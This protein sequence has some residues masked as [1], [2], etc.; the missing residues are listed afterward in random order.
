MTFSEE[1]DLIYSHLNVSIYEF[2]K[3]RTVEKTG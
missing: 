1:F 3:T 2:Q